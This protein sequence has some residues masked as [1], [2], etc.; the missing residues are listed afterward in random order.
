MSELERA[1]EAFRG[2]LF[3]P[4]TDVMNGDIT[5]VWDSLSDAER[6]VWI[7]FVKPTNPIS[8]ASTKEAV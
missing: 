4:I 2:Y 6:Q 7:N 3:W 5:K 1:K 8:V